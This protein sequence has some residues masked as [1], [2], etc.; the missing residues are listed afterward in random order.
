MGI[1]V[2]VA[3]LKFHK[4]HVTACYSVVTMLTRALQK[5]YVLISGI[6]QSGIE[7]VN[8]V[9][10]RCVSRWSLWNCDILAAELW[11]CK[12]DFCFLFPSFVILPSTTTFMNKNLLLEKKRNQLP[13][14]GRF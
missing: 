8:F 7:H 13:T 9:R 12:P 10:F 5:S 14:L 6:F 2:A 4:P 11:R 3:V 1:A